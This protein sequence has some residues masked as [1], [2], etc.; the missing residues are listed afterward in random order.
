MNNLYERLGIGPHASLEEI[1][2]AFRRCARASHPD[3]QGDANRF[4]SIREAYETLSDPRKRV[5]YEQ[6]RRAWMR[7]IGAIECQNCGHANRITKRPSHGETA[8]CGNC[9]T[10]LKF[11]LSDAVHAQRQALVNE[12][13]RFVDEVGLDLAELAADAVRAGIGRLRMRLGL[14]EKERTDRN[15]KLKP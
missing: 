10:S 8:C 1:K 6:E 14:S 15:N 12:T 5:A 13:A 3:Y 11:T 2:A 9:K 4:H 7:K